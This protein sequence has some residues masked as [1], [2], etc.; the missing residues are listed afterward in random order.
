MLEQ[1]EL[2]LM[3]EWQL[4]EQLDTICYFLKSVHPNLNGGEGFRPCVEIRPIN[5]GEE[6]FM[7]SKSLML[8]DLQ[9][10]SV[11]RLR[12]FLARHNGYP[13]CLFYSV[14]YYDNHKK[15]VTEA[16]KSKKSSR[17]TTA[18]AMGTSEIA[19]DFDSISFETYVDLVDRF[20][21]MGIYAIWVFS[22]HGYQAQILLEVNIEDTD[23]LRR[24]VYKFRS[25]GFDCDPSCVDPARL[26]RLPYT[27]NCKCFK[28]P[29]YK[30][31][32]IEP[33]FCKIM[34]GSATRYA[35]KDILDKLDTLPTVS[36]ADED[37]L[38]KDAGASAKNK[39][40][41]KNAAAETG[42]D[43]FTVR[44]VEYP[45]LSNYEL[46][47]AVNKMLAYTPHGVRNKVLGYLIR[48]FKT[49]YKLS[50]TQIHEIL[51]IWSQEACEVGWRREGQ[52]GGFGRLWAGE[53][54]SQIKKHEFF[55][56]FCCS[57]HRKR[58]F[59]DFKRMTSFFFSYLHS[60]VCLYSPLKIASVC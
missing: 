25:K 23:I 43:S 31:E 15:T 37:L 17:I 12:T 59:L 9:P 34:Q 33:P 38:K 52:A 2:L 4:E 20:E 46:P 28:D 53:G 30:D 3:P 36:K 39:S 35:L 26:M 8:W 41:R 48:L 5:R 14:Y 58:T 16:G 44:K 51:T 47:E 13:A 45:Y 11:E 56:R 21:D 19:L 22:G 32:L 10:D 24:C 29:A 60:P 18:S 42:P 27:Y 7:L 6:D 1:N 50:K 57:P 54:L 49:Q 40:S 55:L